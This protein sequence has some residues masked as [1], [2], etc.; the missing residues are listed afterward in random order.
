MVGTCDGKQASLWLNGRRVGQWPFEGPLRPGPA[1]LRLGGC[2]Q[3]RAVVNLLDGDL[4][5]VAIACLYL[6]PM[7]LVG[8]WHR[9]AAF[10]TAGALGAI[11]MLKHTWY[12]RL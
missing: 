5:M 8:R 6:A 7:Y 9:Y 1:P 11:G 3:D 4:G 10:C 2:G 12:D